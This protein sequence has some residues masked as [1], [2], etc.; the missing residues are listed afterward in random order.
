M[1]KHLLFF[2]LII[3]LSSQ[4]YSQISFEDGYFLN[5]SGQKTE[6]LIKN[7]D[8]KKNP[9]EFEYKLSQSDEVQKA[10]VETV[11]E[12]GVNGGPKYISAKVE[13]DRSSDNPGKLGSSKNPD[14]REELLFLKVLIEGKASLYIYYDDNITRLFYNL[15]D[16]AITQLV[17]KRYLTDIKIS[18]NN[19]FRQQLFLDLKCEGITLNDVKSIRY[20]RTDVKRFFIKYND[21]A[22]SGYIDFEPKKKKDIFNLTLRPGLNYNSLTIQN[23]SAD[24]KDT[25]FENKLNFRFGIEAELILPFNKNKWSVIVEPT[26][27]SYKSEITKE[28]GNISGGELLSKVN[29]QSVELPVGLRHYFFLND[30]SKVFANISFIFDFPGNSSIEFSRSDGSLID[31]MKIEMGTNLGLGVGYKFKDRYSLEMRYQTSREILKGY[32]SWGS[33][34]KTLSV[35]VGYTLF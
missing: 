35:I 8:W 12:F 24:L 31:Q 10:T 7:I 33:K 23:Y 27:Q 21:C 18:E 22:K 19:L 16:S 30:E 3:V 32:V 15:P 29:Y 25:E 11:K 13:I 2:V 17:Y 4:S 5:E 14:F 26:W 20:N 1:K 28:T 9:V 34:Y 6:C